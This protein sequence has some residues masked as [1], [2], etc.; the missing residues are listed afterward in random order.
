MVIYKLIGRT[1]P[2]DW[3]TMPKDV[4]LGLFRTMHA[5]LTEKEWRE[6]DPSFHMDWD[7]LF[8]LEVELIG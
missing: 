1:S 3:A 8:V 6:K 7:H 4:E 2:M 5:A